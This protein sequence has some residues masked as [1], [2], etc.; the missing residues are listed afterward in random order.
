MNKEIKKV[1]KEKIRRK[2]TTTCGCHS[3]PLEKKSGRA[4]GSTLLAAA[5][6]GMALWRA[7]APSRVWRLACYWLGL[8]VLVGSPVSSVSR[9]LPN[10]RLVAKSGDRRA[11]GIQRSA[12]RL[13]VRSGA[14]RN[15]SDSVSSE[16]RIRATQPC[17]WTACAC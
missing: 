17:D 13:P 10:G 12:G 3:Q 8:V 9:A 14:T 5:T 16:A 2:R 6:N 1:T 11:C 7:P 15:S 4:L